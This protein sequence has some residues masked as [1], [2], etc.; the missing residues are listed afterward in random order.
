MNAGQDT[1]TEP[2]EE[3]PVTERTCLLVILRPQLVLA[4][5]LKWP[6]KGF[7]CEGTLYR[8]AGLGDW[9]EFYDWLRDSDGNMLGVRYWLRSD[10]EFLVEYAKGR[11]YIQTDPPRQI[12]IYFSERRGA[13]AKL[14]CDQDFLYDAVFRSESGDYAIAFGMGGLSESDLD[15]L[16]SAEA[17][18]VE[19]QAAS[20]S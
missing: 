5:N 15:R 18:W 8:D 2:D 10:T 1:V 16:E 20:A 3:T 4:K 19:A 6:L 11:D 9:T 7:I 13:N 17:T 12:E 14:S